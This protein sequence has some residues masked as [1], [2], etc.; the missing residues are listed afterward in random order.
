MNLMCWCILS[1]L[2]SFNGFPC[3]LWCNAH[4]SH[5]PIAALR[6]AVQTRWTAK[7]HCL[8]LARQCKWCPLWFKRG[9]GLTF[10]QRGPFLQPVLPGCR[11]AAALFLGTVAVFIACFSNCMCNEMAPFADSPVGAAMSLGFLWLFLPLC[12]IG[13]DHSLL[14]TPFWYFLSLWKVG[15][16]LIRAVQESR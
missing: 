10:T 14:W 16:E 9:C 1:G 5:T 11:A 8:N 6:Q 7:L 15:A 13:Q 3:V 4:R 12:L 2:A